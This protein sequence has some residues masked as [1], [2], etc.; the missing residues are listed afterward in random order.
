MSDDEK[1]L[2]LVD[3][4]YESVERPDLWPE[5][6]R[7]IDQLLGGKPRL[8]IDNENR[9]L[10]DGLATRIAR[11][12][13]CHGTLFLSRSDLK[14]LDEYEREFGELIFKF[15]KI[16]F[17]SILGAPSNV[18]ARESMGLSMV[19]KFL[20]GSE[21]AEN[22]RDL[23][24]SSSAYRMVATLW[25]HG[26]IFDP[27]TL[28]AMRLLVPHLDRAVRLQMRST[29]AGLRA[30]LLSGALDALTLGVVLVDAAGR[31]LWLNRRAREIVER[32]N[33]LRVGP[34][35]LIAASRPDNQSL[36]QL[37]NKAISDGTQGLL[38]ISRGVELRSLLLVTI[39][40]KPEAT[41]ELP[42]ESPCAAIFIS[43]PDQVVNPS[44]EALRR[45]FDLTY[46]EAQTAI[47]VANGHGLKAAAK[48]MGV[49]VTTA[50]SQLQQ[51]FAKTGT[52]QQAELAALVHRTLAPLRYDRSASRPVAG[53]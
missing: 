25:E 5:T 16:V 51:A 32:S 37:I 47:A 8:W 45:A 46:R 17:L 15:L 48:S 53:S 42:A 44:V 26:H 33:A 43:D 21:H 18:G 20:N 1:L 27:A 14:Q 4:I 13:A 2:V 29:S 34:T 22:Q 40:L 52:R 50:R 41:H 9:N 39:P 7:A 12:P 19:R 28:R 10:A 11:Q 36:S 35:G 38:A 6:I 23:T 24:G 49:A 30:D 31:P 3:R